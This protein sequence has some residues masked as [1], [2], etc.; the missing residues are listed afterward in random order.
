MPIDAWVRE[1]VEIPPEGVEV[2]VEE[3]TVRV[4]GRRG[5]S[6][7]GSSSTRVSEYSRRTVR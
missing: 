4:K 2:T 6:L 5:G 3:N 1:E 7:R